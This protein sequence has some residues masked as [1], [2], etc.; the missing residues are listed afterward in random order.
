[1]SNVG[2][3]AT[4]S[5][6]S[7][8]PAPAA[9]ATPAPAAPPAALESPRLRD[10][11]VLAEIA[12]GAATLERGARGETVKTI[13]QALL[14]LGVAVRGGADGA[15]GTGTATALA[16]F[17]R[18]KGL[19]PS[20][21]LDQAT[22]VALDRGLAA[23]A[24]GGTGASGATGA[25]GGP[26]PGASE[27][28][29]FAGD[30]TLR[31]VLEGRT[32]L[33]P[34]ARG[35]AVQKVQQAL[36]DIGFNMPVYGAD[37]GY[38][39]EAAKAVSRFQ[40]DMGLSA[41]GRVDKKTLEALARVA[42]PPGKQLER[43]PEYDELF[44][45]GR[46]D[47]TIAQGFDENGTADGSI[48]R[49]Q[50]GLQDQG[51]RRI[52]PERMSEKEREKLGVGP[53][54]YEK[55]ATYFTKQIT[56]PV[57]R[58]PVD[59]V[60]KLITPGSAATPEE[61]RDMFKRAL[62]R[63]EVVSYNGHARYG[64]GPDF[65]AIDSGRGN[66]VIDRDGGPTG[67]PHAPLT[68]AL[69]NKPESMLK[70]L[71]PFPGKYQLLY[72]NACTTENYM[73]NLRDPTKFAGRTTKNTDIIGS[74]IPTRL[75]TGADHVLGFVDMLANRRSINDW[76]AA[77]NKREADM[78]QGFLDQGYSA[79]DLDGVDVKRAQGTFFESGFVENAANRIR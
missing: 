25:T 68:T 29:R 18:Q 41:T 14:D 66:F 9:P 67:H 34:G 10:D 60:V 2:R 32:T 17:Q 7:L 24:A 8:T 78:I 23:H 42:P 70:D 52:D 54:R 6:G 48:W 12:R 65:D 15:F 53:D 37:G 75:A 79:A 36:L 69:A 76:A 55:G 72:F 73:E 59:V 40:R 63:D 50:R 1:M 51:F 35:P 56:D 3:T 28:P 26:T 31:S 44:Q 71:R 4:S 16:T 30:P 62:E 49:L 38:G 47:M 27:N 11:P 5:V 22:L 46:L 58:K 13:Q 61:V 43:N 20:G 77:E 57:S 74:T 33:G 21:A 64:T 39:S 45:D 19:T